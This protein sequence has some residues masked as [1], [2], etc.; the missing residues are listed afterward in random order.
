[1]HFL[2]AA[3]GSDTVA[4]DSYTAREACEQSALCHMEARCLAE[5]R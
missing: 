5:S 1:M 4:K 2:G 3:G